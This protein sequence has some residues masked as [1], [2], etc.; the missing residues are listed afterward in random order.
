LLTS[1]NLPPLWLYFF[2]QVRHARAVTS[3]IRRVAAMDEDELFTTAKHM[4]APL[5]LVKVDA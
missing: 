4:Q 3:E 1:T 5:E 2:H